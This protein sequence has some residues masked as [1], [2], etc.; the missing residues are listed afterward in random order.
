MENTPTDTNLNRKLFG[1]NFKWGVSVAALQ[2]EGACDADGKGESIWDIFS[3]KKGKILNGDHPRDACDF[4]NQYK[5]DIDIIAQL[6]IPC[7]RFS[8]SWT[9]VLP[10]G[11]G[12]VNQAGLDF[13]NRVIDY[14]ISKGVEP[15][16]TIYHWDL[17]Q[18]LEEKG[19]WTNRE[20]V[21]WFENFV[22][23]CAQNF[24]DRVKHWMVMNEPGVF[25][26]AGYFL[27]IHAPGR[28][29]LKNFLPAIHHAVLCMAEGGRILRR[30]IPDAEIGTTFSCSHVEPH[31]GKPKDVA[32]A[33]RVDALL[34]R[35]FIEPVLGL[36]YPGD[37]KA[38]KGISKYFQ[39]GDEEA[40]KFDFDFI[41]VQN[42]TREIVRSSFFTPYV[43]ASLVKAEK[44]NVE[45]TDMKWEVYPP[46]IYHMLRQ[47][48]SYPQVKKIYIT[49]NGAAFPDTVEDA[50]VDDP[51]RIAY[52]KGYL[53]QV[54]R[55]KNEGVNVQGYFIWTLTDNFEWAEG[56]HPRFG[57]VYIDF[58]TQQRIVKSSARWYSEFLKG[59]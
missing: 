21:S 37:V 18:A 59:G 10:F 31:T 35:L 42:Y 15:W 1:D 3:S 8:I 56:Y 14:C 38:L 34:N 13:Y 27:G 32:A 11:V 5:Q 52:L 43:G 24:G 50:K 49:E 30:L 46:S 55:A 53:Q 44:R 19:G 40:M 4:Y 26:G 7:F 12:D 16:L 48:D 41:G 51:K 39:H 22:T 2:I 25:T 58:E 9:R 47:F 17:P 23:I 33:K 57:L 29:G 20:I 54:L 28:T 45:L 36:G 6:H